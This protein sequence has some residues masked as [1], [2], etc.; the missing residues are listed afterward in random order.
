MYEEAKTVIVEE[1]CFLLNEVLAEVV[2][3]L[4]GVY[5]TPKE[6]IVET[7]LDFVQFENI[8]MYESKAVI[9]EALTLYRDKNL[10]FVDCCLCAMKDRF[11]VKSF[12]KKLMICVH[13]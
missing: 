1:Y 5:E 8:K 2:Y 7:L 4:G 9:V 3:V 10:D 6:V 11:E 13:K 12:D